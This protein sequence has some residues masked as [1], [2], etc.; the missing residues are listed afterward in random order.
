MS[1]FEKNPDKSGNNETGSQKP[2]R[3]QEPPRSSRAALVWLFILI[4]IGVLLLFKGYGPEHQRE[5]IASAFDKHLAAKEIKTAELSRE[6]DG[7]FHING[8]LKENGSS[9]D[10]HYTT[11]VVWSDALREELKAAGVRTE[12]KEDSSGIWNFILVKPKI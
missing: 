11:R 6:G 12:I 4:G 1:D 2:R 10:I 3:R 9:K 8:T 5:L 7:I